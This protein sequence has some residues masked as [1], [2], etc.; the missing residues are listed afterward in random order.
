L[1]CRRRVQ[2]IYGNEAHG[3]VEIL[4]VLSAVEEEI[5]RKESYQQI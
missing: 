3:I 1:D 2:P 4:P 5:E